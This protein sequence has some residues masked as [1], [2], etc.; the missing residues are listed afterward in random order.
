MDFIFGFSPI[1]WRSIDSLLD[2]WL[3]D[4]LPFLSLESCFWPFAIPCITSPDIFPILVFG[5]GGLPFIF[6]YSLHVCHG[7]FLGR[8]CHLPPSTYSVTPSIC[9]D[10][11]SFGCKR[12]GGY[13][14]IFLYFHHYLC[15]QISHLVRTWPPLIPHEK[16][17]TCYTMNFIGS[18]QYLMVVT[19]ICLVVWAICLSGISGFDLDYSLNT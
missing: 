17:V 11:V 12:S 7:S 15:P 1:F 6:H 8:W 14:L 13:S 19:F 2:P 3:C 10:Y 9:W 4:L 5:G 18:S 16:H